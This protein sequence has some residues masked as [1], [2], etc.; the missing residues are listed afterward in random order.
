MNVYQWII[1]MTIGIFFGIQAVYF[2]Y[3]N[4]YI[5]KKFNKEDGMSKKIYRNL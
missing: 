3:T 2:I 5:N 4:N 1:I